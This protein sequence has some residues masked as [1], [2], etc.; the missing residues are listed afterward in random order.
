MPNGRG[1]D[2]S[3]FEADPKQLAEELAA[4]SKFRELEKENERLR[5]ELAQLLSPATGAPALNGFDRGR[6]AQ[7]GKRELEFTR[8][9]NIEPQLDHRWLI[10]GIM[11]AEQTTVV[12][13]PPSCGKT[14]FSLDIGLHV[15]AKM[16][17]R[18]RRV[19]GGW[20]IYVAAEAGR[21]IANRVA[22]WKFERMREGRDVKFA[23]ITSPVDLCH[24]RS[25]DVERLIGRIKA[26]ISGE[27]VALV[28]IDTVNRVLFSGD[29]N[30]S[31]DMGAL[32]GA[33]DRIREQ[34]KCHVLAIHHTGKDETKGSR[35]HSLLKGNTDTEIEVS[36]DQ[37][38][39][40]STAVVL[41][42]RD[43]PRGETIAFRLRSVELGRDSDDEPVASCVLEPVDEAP[44]K[45]RRP[46]SGQA[47]IAFQQLSNALAD[48][49][50]RPPNN[51][52]YP[53]GQTLVVTLAL[54]RTYCQKAGLADRDND[55][56][57]RKAFQ[58]ARQSLVSNGHI[59]IWDDLV[60]I[61]P[62]TAT[63]RD[64]A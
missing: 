53:A 5:R 15:A 26:E 10:K 46:P 20:V 24:L 30:S 62:Q 13:G 18:G 3:S 37:D 4:K 61:V 35:G 54:W 28:I 56:A 39:Q 48:K 11:L 21:G 52:K 50:E 57:F 27:P 58:R 59:C 44:P 14:F 63:G 16:D 64:K 40:V 49:G 43:G 17:W 33:F 19:S 36:H 47:G 55:A 34:L 31:G 45:R 1:G 2:S 29:E 9:E 23:I 32:F 8:F 12:F 51:S 60:W 42:Q 41:K 38:A 7:P 22:A 6:P 25:G